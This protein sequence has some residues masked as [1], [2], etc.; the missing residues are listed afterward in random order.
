MR[1]FFTTDAHGG[2]K[3][4]IQCLE[5][6]KFNIEEDELIY[7]GDICDGWGQTKECIDLLMSIKNLK[8]LMGNHDDWFI[9]YYENRLH[10]EEK[11][12]WLSHG[13]KQALESY[14]NEKISKEHY[15]FLKQNARAYYLSE[16]NKLFVHA[17]IIEGWELNTHSLED[18]IWSAGFLRNCKTLNRAI[19]GYDEIFIGHTPTSTIFKDVYLPLNLHNVWAIDTAACFEGKLTI[20]DVDTKEYW[21]SDIVR[22]LYPDE[23]GRNRMSWNEILY[24]RSKGL[25]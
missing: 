19:K 5:L 20:I 6:A 4:L 12:C 7:G 18:F 24:L 15:K 1:R 2:Y 9:R 23:K 3:A 10:P 14:P 25:I 16:D 17:G 8:L 11:N 21:Q 22:T 13:G